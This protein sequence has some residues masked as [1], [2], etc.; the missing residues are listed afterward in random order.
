MA[1]G[2]YGS[3]SESFVLRP[4]AP[5]N[6]N[7]VRRLVREAAD[8]LRKSKI[9][10][11]WAKPWPDLDRRDERMLNDLL[12]GKTWLLWDGAA[13]AAT[14]TIDDD[15]PVDSHDNPVWPDDKRHQT[16]L[17][18]RRIVVSRRYY[19]HGL[20]AGLLDWAATVAMRDY[21]AAL[22]RV[23]VW[24]TNHELHMY[25]EEQRF[26]RCTGRDPSELPDYPS[27][28]LFE[29]DASE[30]RSTHTGLFTEE[31]SP[32]ERGRRPR[33]SRP[34]HQLPTALCRACEPGTKP[35][36]RPSEVFP[37]RTKLANVT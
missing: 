34:P 21:G 5:V 9:T 16:A 18:V 37:A 7:E 13:A 6:L 33:Q 19:H 30:A 29:R 2:D 26:K 8:W 36:G 12:K 1:R 20:G 35:G 22:I 15:E 24:T 4:A 31:E 17:Y 11:Q 3:V 23:D 27:Q 14:I 10:D 28:A 32:P 25:Y